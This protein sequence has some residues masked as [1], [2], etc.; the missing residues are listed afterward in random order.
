MSFDHNFQQLISLGKDRT[1]R[2]W[3]FDK[4]MDIETRNPKITK[5]IFKGQ[6]LALAFDKVNQ[7]YA[8]SHENG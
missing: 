7:K 3:Q 8:T 6:V 2:I 4:I 1:S 5:K